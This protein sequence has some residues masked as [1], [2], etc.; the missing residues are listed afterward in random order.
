MKQQ[1]SE[2]MNTQTSER[3]YDSDFHQQTA[4]PSSD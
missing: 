3:T 2:G 1:I 4:R